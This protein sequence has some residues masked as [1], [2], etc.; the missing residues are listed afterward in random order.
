MTADLVEVIEHQDD[1]RRHFRQSGA[2]LPRLG[3]SELGRRRDDLQP[4]LLRYPA[5]R[6]DR[7]DDV[8][9]E[10]PQIVVGLVQAQPGNRTVVAADTVQD[11]TVRVLPAPGP[12]HTNVTGPAAPAVNRSV[13]KR[14]ST[15]PG[16][17]TGG[18]VFKTCMDCAGPGNHSPTP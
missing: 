8:G 15:K 16:G 13:S 6:E 14:R 10:G 3:S 9:P 18:C 5:T 7:N 4:T 1:R 2:D 11:A 17:I 12:A